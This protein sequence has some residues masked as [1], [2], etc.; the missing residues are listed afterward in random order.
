MKK[1]PG[2]VRQA[3]CAVQV[4]DY[5]QGTNLCITL[6]HT[7]QDAKHSI[8]S[9]ILHQGRLYCHRFSADSIVDLGDDARGI[10]VAGPSAGCGTSRGQGSNMGKL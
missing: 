8:H 2:I 10:K 3:F 9:W 5:V 7:K 1:K 4:P 6:W